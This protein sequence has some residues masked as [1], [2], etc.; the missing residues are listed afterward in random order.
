MRAAEIGAWAPVISK[1][2]DLVEIERF[3]EAAGRRAGA[4]AS[5]RSG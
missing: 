4:I 5:K 3:L 1:P 2:F